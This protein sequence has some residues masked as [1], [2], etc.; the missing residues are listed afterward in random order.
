MKLLLCEIVYTTSLKLLPFLSRSDNILTTFTTKALLH[1]KSNLPPLWSV[2]I[3]LTNAANTG[4]SVHYGDMI[5]ISLDV[6]LSKCH[7]CNM[8]WSFIGC[9][10]HLHIEMSLNY[11]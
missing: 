3:I 7:I 6:V 9:P 8:W 4:R 2:L 1:I 11:L 10:S 5:M